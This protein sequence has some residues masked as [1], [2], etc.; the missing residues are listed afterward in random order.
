LSFQTILWRSNLLNTLSK[1][2]TATLW[3][4]D[5]APSFD[6]IRAAWRA[7]V[8][9][10]VTRPGLTAV[11]HLLYA[12]LLGKDWRGGFGDVTNSRKIENGALWNTGYVR[13]LASIRFAAYEGDAAAAA[14]LAPFQGVVTVEMLRSVAETLPRHDTHL[15]GVALLAAQDVTER[16]AIWRRLPA[17]IV[18]V[19][20]AAGS[21]E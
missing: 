11:H 10:P 3:L 19:P 14:L 4:K 2:V 21:G 5:G 16:T 17:Y 20:A 13:S 8:H 15:L 7:A 9:D 6:A 18:S 12:A 1:S